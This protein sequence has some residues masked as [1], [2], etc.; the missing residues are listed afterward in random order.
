M[1]ELTLHGH[2][3]SNVAPDRCCIKCA[4]NK[5]PT[6]RIFVSNTDTFI[7]LSKFD[8]SIKISTTR[9]NSEKFPI[10]AKVSNESISVSEQ[11]PQ[12]LTPSHL[13]TS[14][15]EKNKHKYWHY[16]ISDEFLANK[17]NYETEYVSILTLMVAIHHNPM[18][19][20]SNHYMHVGT[21]PVLLP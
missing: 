5:P 4:P 10:T 19:N 17:V 8:F 13:R 7:S 16:T 20:L 3:V 14:S 12:V 2:P 21:F 15:K 11:L 18:H 1:C 9:R 6:I